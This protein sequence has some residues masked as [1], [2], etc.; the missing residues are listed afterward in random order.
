MD[1]FKNLFNK[2]NTQKP[3]GA[4]NNEIKEKGKFEVFGGEREK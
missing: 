1:Y 4:P 2:K 3:M